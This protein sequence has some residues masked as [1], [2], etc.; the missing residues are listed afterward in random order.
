MA[1]CA[2]KPIA[3]PTD[4]GA[5]F[6]DF[7]RVHAQISAACAGV[8]TLT[9]EL[10]LSGR[11][12]DERL[13]GPVVA[14]FERPSSMRLEGVAPFGQPVFILAARNG[15]GTLLLPRERRILRSAAPEA[16][17]EALTGVALAPADL[18]AVLTGC[19]VPAPRAE[20]GR[21]HAGGWAS[22][23]VASA[24]ES[25]DARTATLFLRLT[26]GAWQL[27]AARRDRWQIEYR[28]AQGAFPESVRLASAR[29]ELRVDITASLSQIET[30]T[31]IDAA[32][33]TIEEPASVTP[34][35]IEELR[36]AGPL[37]GE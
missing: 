34:L 37:R 27:R 32:A 9:L 33:F 7:A 28:L 15:S 31:G 2:P 4:P 3:L 36:D 24:P 10:G 11:A 13:R 25:G 22:I 30:N 1:S 20:S 26:G 35:S 14:G 8:R 23:D 21:I 19:V 17:L 6:A 16:I 29:P 12:G 18:Q 5:P